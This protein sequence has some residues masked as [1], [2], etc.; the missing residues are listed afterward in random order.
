[1][2]IIIVKHRLLY[3]NRQLW[4]SEIIC[5][6]SVMLY[7]FFDNKIILKGALYFTE[8]L[9]LVFTVIICMAN[10]YV[11][12]YIAS[13]VIIIIVKDYRCI[14]NWRLLADFIF[15]INGYRRNLN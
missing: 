9:E 5:L 15:V 3:A 13:N 1:M 7:Y 8:H 6:I 14:P 4:F 12:M 10:V 11:F 2:Y